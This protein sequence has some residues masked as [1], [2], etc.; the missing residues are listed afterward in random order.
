MPE[1]DAPAGGPQVDLPP[2][3]TRTELAAFWRV[4]TRTIDRWAANG[5]CPAPV[6]IGNRLLWRRDEVLAWEA[7]GQQGT[8]G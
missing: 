8:S 2:R 7:R 3:L 1:I 4:S 6:R 5:R